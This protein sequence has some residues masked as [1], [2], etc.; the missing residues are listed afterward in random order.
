MEVSSYKLK[1]KELI[2]ILFHDNSL[3]VKTSMY[4]RIK[5]VSVVAETAL[6]FYCCM[7]TAVITF[8]DSEIGRKLVNKWH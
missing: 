8:M 4:H 5:C 7:Q 2:F 6:I 1:D 3:Y